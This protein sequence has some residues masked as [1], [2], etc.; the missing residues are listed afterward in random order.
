MSAS[1]QAPARRGSVVLVDDDQRFRELA[2]EMLEADGYDVL[3]EADTAVGGVRLVRQLRPDV[4]VL[5]LVMPEVDAES[6]DATPAGEEIV[7]DLVSAEESGL[8]AA[9]ELLA[10][11]ASVAIVIVSSLFDPTVEHRARRLGATY[12][13]KVAGIDALERAIDAHLS[14]RVAH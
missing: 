5:D 13:D 7:L 9:A 4:V 1:R 2:R 8:R 6:L 3:G 11:D 12:I 14:E 10:H